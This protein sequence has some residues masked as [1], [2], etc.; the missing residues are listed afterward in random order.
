MVEHVRAAEARVAATTSALTTGRP[1]QWVVI[2]SHAHNGRIVVLSSDLATGSRGF[3]HQP[4]GCVLQV[5]KWTATHRHD[6]RGLGRGREFD[7]DR[8]KGGLF[9]RWWL[10]GWVDGRLE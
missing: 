8:A 10:A 6:R 4:R 3:A 5:T 2:S 1:R 7:V 9:C